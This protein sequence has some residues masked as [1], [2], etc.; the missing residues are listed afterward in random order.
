M[1]DKVTVNGGPQRVKTLDKGNDGPI[2]R[3]VVTATERPLT[4]DTASP[5]TQRVIATQ[6]TANGSDTLIQI[7]RDRVQLMTR[8]DN[9]ENNL[10][11]A[12]MTTTSPQNLEGFGAKLLER[13]QRRGRSP[14]TEVSLSKSDST[15]GVA[16]KSPRSK[17]LV[18][19]LD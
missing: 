5:E 17:R 19:A 6:K 11:A 14:V 9:G 3:R 10:G 2:S 16:L 13:G 4:N 7:A 15:N 18:N 8:L 1:N 12:T